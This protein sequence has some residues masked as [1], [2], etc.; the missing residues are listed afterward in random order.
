MHW[1]Y[2]PHVN[3]WA[4]R[5]HENFLALKVIN[6]LFPINTF[7]FWIVKKFRFFVVRFILSAKNL[8]WVFFK[9]SFNYLLVETS[10]VEVEIFLNYCRLLCNFLFIHHF[11]RLS[12]WLISHFY[13]G[14]RIRGCFFFLFKHY[15]FYF[16]V[17]L[18]LRIRYLLLFYNWFFFS[19]AIVIW[20]INTGRRKIVC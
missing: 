16:F 17:F 15:F 8:Y 6:Q 11:L 2:S 12:S 10:I 3:Y 18:L 14:C 4:F 19:K 13:K 5:H 1:K 7:Q 9:V 20:K